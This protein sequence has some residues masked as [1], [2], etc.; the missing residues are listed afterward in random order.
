MT[1]IAV[2]TG[3]G[4]GIGRQVC[5]ELLRTGCAPVSRANSRHRLRYRSCQTQKRNQRQGNKQRNCKAC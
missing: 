4:S 5:L 1:Q 3:A 2:V